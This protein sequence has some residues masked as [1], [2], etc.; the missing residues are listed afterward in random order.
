MKSV[1]PHLKKSWSRYPILEIQNYEHDPNKP[2]S[3]FILDVINKYN[4][5]FNTPT[6]T[7]LKKKQVSTMGSRRSFIDMWGLCRNYYKGCTLEEVCKAVLDLAK[8]KKIYGNWFCQTINRYVFSDMPNTYES[9]SIR[10]DRLNV[11]GDIQLSHM[12]EELGYTKNDFLIKKEEA[13]NNAK[14]KQSGQGLY[15][16]IRNQWMQQTRRSAIL[17]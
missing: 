1:L 8:D 9:Y 17:G 12:L 11:S 14:L 16:Q 3:D 10:P 4:K 7:K 5:N 15:Y 13:P 2:M 6:I